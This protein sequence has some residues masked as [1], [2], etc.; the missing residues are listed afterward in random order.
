[1]K[2]NE[3]RRAD[4]AGDRRLYLGV[5]LTALLAVFYEIVAFQTLVFVAD[6]MRAIQIV[7]VALLGLSIGGLVAFALRDRDSG[8]LT[9]R[10]ALALPLAV[11]LAVASACLFPA[12]PWVYSV[13]LML[14]FVAAS[15]LI[16]LAF[17]LAPPHRVYFADLTGAAA[18]AVL[19]CASVPWLREEGSFLAILILGLAVVV[20]FAGAGPGRTEK[21]IRNGAA[22]AA[23]GVVV[24]LGLQLGM[25]FLNFA[26]I[27]RP[28]EDR[29]KLFTYLDRHGDQEGEPGRRTPKLLYSRG[30]L[31]ERIDM[32]QA[33][34]NRIATFFNG[35]G[36][37]H[38]SRA[39]VGAFRG[40]LRL[41]Y[42]LV[43][44]PEVLVIGTA[45]EGIVKTARGL[46]RGPVVGLEINPALVGLMT[47]PLYEWSRRA[48]EGIELHAIDAR[49][50]LRRTGRKFDVISMLNTHRMRNLGNAGQP[51]YL[52]TTEA[53]ADLFGHLKDGGW[54]VLEERDVNDRAR[55][56]IQR[57]VLNAKAVLQDRFSVADPSRHFW[58]YDWYAPRTRAR[59]QLYTSILIRKDPVTDADLAF[60]TDYLAQFAPAPGKDDQGVTVRAMPGRTTGDVMERLIRGSSPYEAYD[61]ATTNLDPF[62]DD[63]PFPFDVLRARKDLR[64]VL[65]PSVALT[66]L[67]GLC[68]V[69]LLLARHVRRSRGEGARTG[70]FGGAAVL[71][72]ALL[73]IGYLTLEVVFIQ[74][75]QLFIGMP[76]LALAT[77]L[78]AM[79]FF[80]GLG[81]LASRNWPKWAHAAALLGIV[82]LALALWAGLARFQ[83]AFIGLPV[84]ARVL[85]TIATLAPLSFLMGT[86]FPYGIAR[87]KERLGDRFAAILFG[88]N[89]AFSALATPLALVIATVHGFR[90]ACLTGTAAYAACLL[91]ALGLGNPTPD[92]SPN[93]VGAVREP[94]LPPASGGGREGG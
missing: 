55:L 70:F 61:R 39:P 43:R 42:G 35:Y 79:L 57:I 4:P 11:L 8:A 50:Y 44:D 28:S 69:A 32:V 73:G 18:G 27:M 21:R 37:D 46:G 51:E 23:A 22:V 59:G 45:A 25:G 36:N 6:Y 88:L 24:V 1:M 81:G 40:D 76:V 2:E 63:R 26:R 60:M 68:P 9:V 66:L 91:L 65:L 77:V 93:T 94:P 52:H 67:L 71:Y 5:W 86:P 64:A 34:E 54:L 53:F 87:V 19:A 30:S 90:A 82:V 29:E 48:Y 12:W 14:P 41:P 20:V 83:A 85:L 49:S 75:L 47:G 38:V 80:S 78:G 31:V 17:A 72:F 56:G 74:R 13:G 89:G 10:A 33:R 3:S 16:S 58:I 7:A 15:V 62:P 84:A 92:P